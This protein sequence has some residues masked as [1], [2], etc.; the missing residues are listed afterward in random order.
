M[1]KDKALAKTTVSDTVVMLD[2]ELYNLT[3]MMDY[4]YSK[5]LGVIPSS[6]ANEAL[7][8]LRTEIYRAAIIDLNVPLLSPLDEAAAQFG[9]T[10]ARY[11]GLYVARMARNFGYRDRQVLI[12]SV[13]RDEEVMKEAKKIGCTYILKGRPKEIKEE[14]EVVL[15]FDPTN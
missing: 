15:S 5:G 11:P 12:Y 7:D 8:I 1:K 14:L 4:L 3:W 9:A 2:D 13:H 10:Y 6:T